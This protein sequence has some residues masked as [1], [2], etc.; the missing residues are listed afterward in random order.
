[1]K[2]LIRMVQKELMESQFERT[3][4]GQP[5]LFEASELEIELNTVH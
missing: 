5:V 1:M 2:E 4:E 3:R